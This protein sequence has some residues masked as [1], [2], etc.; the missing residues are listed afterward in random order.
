MTMTDRP[1]P[2]TKVHAAARARVL[3]LGI[4]VAAGVGLIG[5]MA[6][7]ARADQATPSVAETTIIQRV[8][9]TAD[10]GET[11][12][13][14]QRGSTASPHT[15]EIPWNPRPVQAVVAAPPVTQ[16]QGS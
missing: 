3:T 9:V 11:I 4:S 2:V 1:R 10:Q 14:V 16:S 7:A 13:Y 8:V 12:I 6:L 15:V 5:S